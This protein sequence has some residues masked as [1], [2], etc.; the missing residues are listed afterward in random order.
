MK[1]RPIIMRDWGVKAILEGRKTQT[2]RVIK[3]EPNNF[4][5]MHVSVNHEH[6][7]SNKFTGEITPIKCPYGQLGDR[8]WV[9]ECWATATAYNQLKPSELPHDAPIYY[10]AQNWF[11]LVNDIGNNH[12]SIHMPRW[13]SRINLE[14]TDIRV[15]RLQDITDKDAE[16]EGCKILCDCGDCIDSTPIGDFQD[17]WREI[18]GY[19]SWETN[20]FVWAITFKRLQP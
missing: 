14:I 12:P 13:A 18:H 7:F 2:R 5:Y 10:K 20:P 19:N 6:G 17:K 3:I 1:E 4:E 8:L 9:R 16:A 11:N 15:Q